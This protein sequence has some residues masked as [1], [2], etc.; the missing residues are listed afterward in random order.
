MIEICVLYSN[1]LPIMLSG[2]LTILSA[3]ISCNWLAILLQ[4][5]MLLCLL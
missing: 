2:A 5:W 4:I 3:S 1:I